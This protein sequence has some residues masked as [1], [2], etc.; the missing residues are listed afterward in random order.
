MHGRTIQRR[1]Y[2]SHSCVQCYGAKVEIKLR[3]LKDG[4][5]AV[6]YLELNLDYDTAEQRNGLAW[7]S[8]KNGSMP[9]NLSL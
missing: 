2:C 6:E 4:R 8:Q 9:G 7:Y 1:N 3:G 5:E